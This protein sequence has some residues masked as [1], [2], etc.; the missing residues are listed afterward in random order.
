MVIGQKAVDIIWNV[1]RL[2][3]WDCSICCVDAI[4]VRKNRS[5]NSIALR[6]NGL[7]TRQDLPIDPELDSFSSASRHLQA[8]GQELSLRDKLRVVDHLSGFDAR[9]DVSGGDPLVLAE[10]WELLKYASKK[11]GKLNITV[12]ATGLGVHA[13]ETDAL[14]RL[15]G[16]FNFTYDPIFAPGSAHE[17]DRPKGYA[18]GN[19]RLASRLAKK[20]VFVRAELPLTR[21]N[22]KPDN[23]RRIYSRLADAGI[24]RLL[25]MRLFPVGRGVGHNP[26]IPTLADYLAAIQIFRELEKSAET[27][28]VRLQCAL[29]HLEHNGRAQGKNPC[30]MLA[31][32]FGLMADGTLLLSPWAIGPHGS[33]LSNEWVLGNLA[34][35]PLSDIL[36][37]N[38]VGI[39]E[40]QLDA[41]FGHCKIFAYLN[42]IETV[43]ENRMLDKADPLFA[44]H[45]ERAVAQ[46]TPEDE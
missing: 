13:R 31:K 5:A 33:P 46:D 39:L 27:P 41:N 18:E 15:I 40:R 2:C 19:L 9:L 14:A 37:E 12:T 8:I 6:T 16:E 34:R 20:G 3:P 11:L 29:R 17:A 44:R 23:L 38:R 36:A 42:S 32:S 21:H 1:T 26:A 43:A 10:N 4:H 30:D 24:H 7:S 22:C 45:A 25:L 28:E 35:A